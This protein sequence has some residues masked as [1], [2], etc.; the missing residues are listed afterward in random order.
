MNTKSLIL[1][2]SIICLNS[3]LFLPL[4]FTY[5]LLVPLHILIYWLSFDRIISTKNFSLK[6]SSI[7]FS[8]IAS[9]AQLTLIL[10]L[11]FLTSD[12]GLADLSFIFLVVFILT[13]VE[14]L[15]LYFTY[16][17]YYNKKLINSAGG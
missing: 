16:S 17:K 5:F 11:L 10:F 8:G 13:S 15:I 4:L 9:V 2:I 14:F 12:D 7:K 3:L 6:W 1:Y